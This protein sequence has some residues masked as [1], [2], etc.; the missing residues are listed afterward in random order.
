[1]HTHPSVV[2]ELFSYA[3]LRVCTIVEIWISDSSPKLFK[4][5]SVITYTVASAKEYRRGRREDEWCM[6]FIATHDS[7]DFQEN[8]TTNEEKRKELLLANHT[9]DYLENLELPFSLPLAGKAAIHSH[10]QPALPP[11]LGSH[12]NTASCQAP[13]L[14]KARPRSST[15]TQKKT[16][17]RPPNPTALFL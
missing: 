1:M 16:T 12:S 3:C 5:I 9:M 17:N 10:G 11:D 8:K 4:T 2:Y 6:H 13:T 15:C 7:C 14:V